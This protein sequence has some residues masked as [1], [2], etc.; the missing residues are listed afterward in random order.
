MG[1]LLYTKHAA[2]IP[3]RADFPR[4]SPWTHMVNRVAS[5]MVD[6]FHYV[7]ACGTIWDILALPRISK[8]YAE[9][10]DERA[11]EL[12][13]LSNGRDIYLMWSGG[14]DSTSVLLAFMS[15]LS[16]R[17]KIHI[18]CSHQSV[19]E[20]P[21]MWNVVFQ[22]FKGK[23]HTSFCHPEYY[24]SR[25]VL[26]TG[27]HGDQ[28]MGSDI[29]YDVVAEF[30]E[31][32]LF[33]PWEEVM[34]KT[35]ERLFGKEISGPFVARYEPLISACPFP[36]R[37]GFDWV[38]WFNFTNK[39][40][41]VKYRLLGLRTWCYPQTHFANIYHFFDTPDWQRWSFDHHDEKIGK[42][43]LSYK[44]V[45]KKYIIDQTKFTSYNDKKKIGSLI[46]LWLTSY[47]YD[48]LNTNLYPVTLEECI[49]KIRR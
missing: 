2:N 43:V 48:G 40:Q 5:D 10:C 15:Y 32:G 25:G 34:P 44:K 23:I 47:N 37:T 18:V 17:E 9:M 14:I 20:F 19:L 22:N 29:L 7:N 4:K 6:P 33:K 38:W 27:E 28:I 49:K 46:N 35:Y 42:T 1:L 16:R 8:T 3:L 41:H 45:A 30:G 21:E 26:V 31:E 13:N 12:F 11:V 36:I 24:A 39:W